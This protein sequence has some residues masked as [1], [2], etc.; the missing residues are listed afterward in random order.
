MIKNSPPKGLAVDI[1]ELE[2]VDEEV[3][4]PEKQ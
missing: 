4:K 2:V 3:I 1:K